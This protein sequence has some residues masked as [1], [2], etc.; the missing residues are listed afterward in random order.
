MN[1]GGIW[2]A[3]LTLLWF[4]F[5]GNS[6]EITGTPAE[7][8]F[9]DGFET[10]ACTSNANCDPEAY[11]SAQLQCVLNFCGD[12]VV[13]GGEVCDDFNNLACGTCSA[14]CSQARTPAPATGLITTVSAGDLTDGQG[15]TLN[16]GFT[17]PVTF[18]FEKSGNG[19]APG[20]VPVVLTVA[21]TASQVRDAIILA[22]NNQ[23]SLGITAVNNGASLVGL[24]ND[25]NSALGNQP[26]MSTV[27]G[28]GFQI[29]GMAGGL[30]GDCPASTGCKSNSDCASDSCSNN[31]CN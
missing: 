15:F 27:I 23:A 9:H 31:Q 30:A 21:A 4:P 29:A 24:V 19:V 25:R 10:R 6:S 11:C 28:P 14:A 26:V 18:E 5:A 7:S 16:D 20:S 12:G 22:V 8:S 17:A 1:S 2:L 3:A 13:H